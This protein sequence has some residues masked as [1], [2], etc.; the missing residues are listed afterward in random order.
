M[1]GNAVTKGRPS[2]GQ[3]ISDDLSRPDNTADCTGVGR[4]YRA[5]WGCIHSVE[6][7]K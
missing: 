3:D 5:D 1:A 6:E 4:L 2:A 7:L